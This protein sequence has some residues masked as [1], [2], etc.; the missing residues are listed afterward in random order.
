MVC[1]CGAARAAT[2]VMLWMAA[3]ASE[4]RAVAQDADTPPLELLEF[5]GQWETED[6]EWISPEDIEYLNLAEL[7]RMA[8]QQAA[9]ADDEILEDGTGGN[10]IDGDDQSDGGSDDDN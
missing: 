9:D 1:K 8:E 7:M 6:G 10:E 2:L 4:L 5:L 3:G